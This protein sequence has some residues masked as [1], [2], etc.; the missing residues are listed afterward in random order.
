MKALGIAGVLWCVLV[1]TVSLV[2]PGEAAINV[3]GAGSAPLKV[4]YSSLS[5]DLSVVQTNTVLNVNEAGMLIGIHGRVITGPTGGVGAATSLSI[6][7]DG[8]AASISIWP[9]GGVSTWAETFS[10]FKSGGT[11][12]GD[13]ADDLFY[14]PLAHHYAS[15]ATVQVVANGGS[16]TLRV[17]VVRG[18]RF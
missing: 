3:S 6:S 5:V 17:G 2:L 8:Q 18:V 10:V 9:G 13:Q 15:N 14:I 11:G 4:A 16:G 12:F 1:C 7:I